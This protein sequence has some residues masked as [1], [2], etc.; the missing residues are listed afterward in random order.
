MDLNLV[1]LIP[2]SDDD[3]FLSCSYEERWNHLKP[4]IVELYT[5]RHRS[6]GRTATLDQVAQFMRNQYSFHA[7]CTEYRRRF[8]AW[9][10]TKRMVKEDK[11]AITR[12][13][14]RKKRP[15][16]SISHVTI[17]QDGQNKPLDAKRLKRHLKD[18]KISFPEAIAP[19]L[20]SSWNLPYAAFVSSLPKDP[21][22]PSPFGSLSLTPYYLH[23]QSPDAFTPGHAAAGPTPRMDLVYQKLKEDHT[24]LFLQG[25]LEQLMVE[26]CKEDRRIMVDYFHDFYL[27]SFDLAKNWGLKLSN[28]SLAQASPTGNTASPWTLSDLLNFSSGPSS[29]DVCSASNISLPP[30][31]LCQ[32]SIHVQTVDYEPVNDVSAAAPSHLEPPPSSFIESLQQSMASNDF[33]S[34]PK[35]DLPLAQDIIAQF[36]EG[37]QSPLQLDAWKLAIMAGNVDLIGQ[38]S[39]DN[40]GKPPQGIEAIY[41]FHLAAAFLDGGHICCEIFTTLSGTLGSSFAF[42]HNT[43]NLGHT[44]LDALVVSILRSHTSLHPDAVIYGFNSPNRFPGEEKDICGRWDANTPKV[45]ELFKQGYARIPNKWKHPFCH[46]AVQAVC[47]SMI[48]IFASP[49]S[50]DINTPSGLFVRRCTECGLE[51]KLGP[52]HA[53]VVT[54]FYLA[55]LGMP[56]ETLFGALSV[57]VCLLALGADAFTK[58]NLSVEEILRS[59]EPGKCLHRLLSPLELMQAVPA[60]VIEAWSDDCRI[61]WGCFVQTLAYAVTR[62]HQQPQA[63]RSMSQQ[64]RTGCSMPGWDEFSDDELCDGWCDPELGSEMHRDWLKLPCTSPRIGLLWA[65]IQAELL[66]YRRLREG[67]PWISENFSMIALKR[68]LEGDLSDFLTPL[69]ENKMLTQFTRCG[70]FGQAN[71]FLCPVAQDVCAEYFMNMDDYTRASYIQPADLCAHFGEVEEVKDKTY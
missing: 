33:T 8:R 28:P 13:L 9:G 35:G 26:M 20:L 3:K 37:D 6:D 27:H 41:P 60:N 24:S 40:R 32:W 1:D 62:G 70:W 34:T 45:R 36:L 46:T 10:V 55:E 18:R 15:G 19:G 71:D 23:I 59:S 56:G 12:A 53:L 49:A 52:L 31:Q 11:D 2:H 65:T 25:R 48:T 4:V 29:P 16:A 57:L 66:T 38:L 22:K 69:V 68:W 47:H 67:E 14:V 61:G 17:Q 5:G 42:Y 21:G 63:R 43:D 54:T 64:E 30:T 44:I 50:P 51:L 58:A 7:A 39:E